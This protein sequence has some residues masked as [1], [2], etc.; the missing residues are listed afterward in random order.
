MLRLL[1]PLV[2]ATSLVH[3]D[4]R[5]GLVRRI[6]LEGVQAGRVGVYSR[7]RSGRPRLVVA[8]TNVDHSRGE[9]LLVRLPDGIRGRGQILDRHD[10]EGG[11]VAVSFVRLVDP[12]DVVV[13]RFANRPVAAWIYRVI[14]ERLVEIA[15]DYADAGNTP[16]L[17]GDGVPE[18]IWRSTGR[19]ECGA[20][21]SGGVTRWNAS[22]YIPDGRMYA[23][24]VSVT[25]GESVDG[26]EIHI[27]ARPVRPPPEH[28]RLRVHRD[29]GVQAV[30]VSIDDEIV[31]ADQVITLE[32]DCHTLDV[33]ATGA[34]GSVAWVFLE[35]QP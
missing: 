35:E 2:I 26:L 22:Y 6:R 30:S 15:N 33:N 19:N 10:L 21:V 16:D 25:A 29:P 20:D 31:T 7:Y 14:G 9:V 4:E 28:Y 23:A 34:P 17:D 24:V 1:L 3:A 5:D 18:I 13:E 11:G 12:R 8:A 27:P 32:E